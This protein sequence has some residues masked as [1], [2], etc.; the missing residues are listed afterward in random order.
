MIFRR[1][2]NSDYDLNVS[3]CTGD[4]V[5]RSLQT[6]LARSPLT[7]ES[8]APRFIQKAS[9]FSVLSPEA[10]RDLFFWLIVGA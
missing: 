8:G 2:A 9:N 10:V 4:R 1:H 6:A 5:V 3:T 7:V